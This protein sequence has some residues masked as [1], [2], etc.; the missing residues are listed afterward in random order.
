MRKKLISLSIGTP[1]FLFLGWFLFPKELPHP[2]QCSQMQ[3]MRWLLRDDL[4]QQSDEIINALV[5]RLQLEIE[6][7]LT[8]SQSTSLPKRYEEQLAENISFIK[9]RWFE[10]RVVEFH[11]LETP[12]EK[13]QF[14]SRQINLVES[15]PQTNDQGT[16]ESAFFAEIESW[17][18]AAPTPEAQQ[19]MYDATVSAILRWLQISDL[20]VHSQTVR[21]SL[22]I[23]VEAYLSSG[24]N[25]EENAASESSDETSQF[26]KNGLLL[27]KS[28]YMIQAKTFDKLP[29]DERSAFVTRKLADVKKWDL[30]SLFGGAS[31]GSSGRH[32]TQIASMVDGWIKNANSDEQQVLR[33]FKHEVEKTILLEFIS[34]PLKM[35][36]SQ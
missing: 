33:N 8:A 10:L 22:A 6:N 29:K 5:D 25:L 36:Q 28:W 30:S 18:D 31:N 23:R 16:S 3:V 34:N 27:L 4:P 35:F 26:R 32:L 13:K 2:N 20:S 24:G 1:L 15:W 7:G 21:D 17:I 11:E 19:G 14:L 12:A 9:K